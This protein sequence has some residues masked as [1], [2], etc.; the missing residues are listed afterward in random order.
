MR[1]RQTGVIASCFT[2]NKLVRSS[3]M[4]IAYCF[5]SGEIL[6]VRIT[7]YIQIKQFFDYYNQERVDPTDY[8]H[9]DEAD[10]IRKVFRRSFDPF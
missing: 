4:R 8:I 3:N 6:F 1:R 7:C 10:I 5:A 2:I 9:S